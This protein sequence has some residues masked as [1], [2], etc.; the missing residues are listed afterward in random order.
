MASQAVAQTKI[1]LCPGLTIVGAIS[2]PRG[3]YEAIITVESIDSHGVNLRYSAQV[4][5]PGAI[6]NVTVRRTVLPQDIRNARLVVSW[7]NSSAPRT[8][9]GTTAF[10]PSASVLRSLKTKGEAEIGSI[11]RSNSSLSADRGV[12]PNVFD[13][14]LV[15]KVRRVGAPVATSVIVNNNKVNLPAIRAEGENMGDRAEWLILDDADH[16]IGLAFRLT[17]LSGATTLSRVVKISY[18]CTENRNAT[19]TAAVNEIEKSL[20]ETRRADVYQIYFDFNSDR[21]REESEPTLKQI[22]DALSR[23]A[24]WKLGIEGHTDNIG[25]AS[26]NL[27]L[28]Q[29]RAAAVK[30]ALIQRYR[31]DATRLTSSGAGLSRPKDTN[32]TLEGRARNRRVEL[33]R[34]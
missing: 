33:V 26:Y 6:R 18:A 13:H 30:S 12:H 7:F 16:P 1:P 24:D 14:E 34:T 29:R 3:D 8:L 2:E 27:T 19:S 17:T 25:G 10:G 31:I 11:E 5:T 9:P 23:H 20:L 15:F 28:S 4:E 32:T 22:A 21:I